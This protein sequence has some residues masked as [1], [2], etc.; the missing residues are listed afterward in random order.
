MFAALCCGVEERTF[1]RHL[2]LYNDSTKPCFVGN[3][4]HAV[5]DT[6]MRGHRTFP[7][8]GHAAES[9]A[10]VDV[11]KRDWFTV[12]CAR[13]RNTGRTDSIRVARHEPYGVVTN[14]TRCHVCRNR[15]HCGMYIQ[16]VWSQRFLWRRHKHM[17]GGGTR[18]SDDDGAG[19]STPSTPPVCIYCQSKSLIDAQSYAKHVCPLQKPKEDDQCKFVEPPKRCVYS[20]CGSLTTPTDHFYTR[21][22]SS[23]NW[24]IG[25]CRE[26]YVSKICLDFR[27]SFHSKR[28][29]FFVMISIVEQFVA[30]NLQNDVV[31]PH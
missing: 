27:H 20:C 23:K 13:M 1:N 9:T 6:V 18:D 31:S 11:G 2:D 26:I 25:W 10:K 21:V 16:T 24:W 19:P 8:I 12:E 7:T 17:L 30:S 15:N 3:A 28:T 4:T 5:Y 22:C 14:G 29:T